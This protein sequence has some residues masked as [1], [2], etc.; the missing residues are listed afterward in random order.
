AGLATLDLLERGLI[1]NAARA[2]ERL[3]AGLEGVAEGCPAVRDVRGMGLMVGVEFTTH[4]EAN[5]VERAAFERG[6]LVLECGASTLRLCPPLV[7]DDDLLDV[8]IRL[9]AES[10]A[11]VGCPLPGIAETGG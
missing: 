3:R 6:L 10:L 9:F 8:G 2:G 7:V 1:A 4:E 11:A 5:A